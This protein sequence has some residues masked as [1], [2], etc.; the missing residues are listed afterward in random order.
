MDRTTGHRFRG[1][2]R[3]ILGAAALLALPALLP[4]QQS[5]R[6][7]LR[8][9]LPPEAAARVEAIA[10]RA[11]REGI[12]PGLIVGKALEGAA[13]G[14]PPDRIVPAVAGLARRLG[15]VRALLGPD[16]P[17]STLMAAA[18]AARRGVP[19]EAIRELSRRH[20]GDI[21][22]PLLVLGELSRS[23]VP[24]DRALGVIDSAYQHGQRGERMLAFS[25]AVRRQIARGE[26]PRRAAEIVARRI[27]EG[28]RLPADARRRGADEVRPRETQPHSRRA[29]PV[30][31]GSRPPAGR[32]E[33]R[34]RRP[35][36]P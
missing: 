30:P 35:R 9:A 31:P 1:M 36:A 8:E 16:R 19:A 33:P 5:A 18:E 13:K 28:R 12:P 11:A 25:A 27:R 4:A 32:D 14:V 23:G 6:D 20:R 3:V 29:T 22:I 15:Q 21:A 24:V 2:N 34:H 10:V 17:P 26:S 7:R